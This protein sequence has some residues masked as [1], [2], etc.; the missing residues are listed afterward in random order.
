MKNLITISILAFYLSL[1]SNAQTTNRPYIISELQHQESGQ[2]TIKVIQ[3]KKIDELLGKIID[4]NAHKG[5]IRGYRI[6]IFR[7]NSQVARER[8]RIARSKFISHFPD[9]EAYDVVKA[10]LWRIYVGDFW[11]LNQAFR[12]L[13]QIEPLFPYAFIIP[14][15]LD[16]NK[17]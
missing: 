5:T 4:R 10:P 13:K 14:E 9:I 16:Y 3:D 12:A 6:Q 11:T 8:A 1:Y 17:L 2:G 15:D 7:E